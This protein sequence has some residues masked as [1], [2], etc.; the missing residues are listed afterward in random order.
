M[1]DEEGGEERE[2]RKREINLSRLE[3]TLAH[4]LVAAPS[5]SN[6]SRPT[7]LTLFLFFFLMEIFRPHLGAGSKA[8][9]KLGVSTP[10]MPISLIR[11][12]T[13]ITTGRRLGRESAYQLTDAT[14]DLTDWWG[15]GGGQRVP[16]R[17]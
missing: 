8:R 3:K 9:R 11:L 15:W 12:Q 4:L 17:E 1:V 2:K 13:L 6:E 10:E 16:G 7:D 5:Y 14:D